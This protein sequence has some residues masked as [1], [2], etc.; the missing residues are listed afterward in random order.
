MPILLLDLQVVLQRV[1]LLAKSLIL[2]SQT[3][4][5]TWLQQYCQIMKGSAGEFVQTFKG[6]E[7]LHALQ[8]SLAHVSAPASWDAEASQLTVTE[9]SVLRQVLILLAF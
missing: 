7:L 5:G 8:Q 4:C 9:P 2:L 3:A 1:M 6:G